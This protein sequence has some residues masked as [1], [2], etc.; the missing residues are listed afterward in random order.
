MWLGNR[1]LELSFWR[2]SNLRFDSPENELLY[3][4]EDKSHWI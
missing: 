3:W 2:W 1:M 4:V